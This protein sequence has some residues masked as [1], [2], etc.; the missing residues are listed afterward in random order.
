MINIDLNHEIHHLVFLTYFPKLLN[1]LIIYAFILNKSW[2]FLI[3][4]AT[5]VRM[6]INQKV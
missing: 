6:S 4:K 1:E 5:N 3:E 2:V